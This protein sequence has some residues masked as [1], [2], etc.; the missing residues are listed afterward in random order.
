MRPPG[1]AIQL[2][3]L[4]YFLPD[5][6]P[7]VVLA[8]EGEL[9]FQGLEERLRDGVV[10]RAALAGKRLDEPAILE[11]PAKPA[12]GALAAPIRVH[13]ESFFRIFPVHSVAKG[14]DY[15]ILVDAG[16]HLPSDYLARE[17]VEVGGQAG[18]SFPRGCVGDVAAPH[19]VPLL[20]GEF[21]VQDIGPLSEAFPPLPC[22]LGPLQDTSPFLAIMR[23][24][25]L[26]FATMPI[27]RSSTTIRLDQYL[28]LLA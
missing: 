23:C 1:I 14:V 9:P 26:P 20:D 7:G 4:E 24:T 28:R 6:Y 17:R 5:P 15:Q 11:L 8:I 10:A 12:R 21:P 2:D 25:V 16:G 19:A 27:L 13:H 22:F 18:P 3:E